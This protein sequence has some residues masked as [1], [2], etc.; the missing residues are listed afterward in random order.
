MGS[1]HPRQVRQ[2]RKAANG[3][4]GVNHRTP[5][6]RVPHSHRKRPARK[7]GQKDPDDPK[8]TA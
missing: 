6:L 5:H 7:P 2:R 8:S 3:A 4:R 1:A